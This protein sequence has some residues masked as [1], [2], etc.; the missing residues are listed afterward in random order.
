M[1]FLFEPSYQI[2]VITLNSTMHY[3]STTEEFQP[4]TSQENDVCIRLQ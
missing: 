2:K 1:L 4:R 3:Q